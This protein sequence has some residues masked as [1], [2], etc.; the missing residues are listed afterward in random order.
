VDVDI[1]DPHNLCDSRLATSK[2]FVLFSYYVLIF[3]LFVFGLFCNFFTF[4]FIKLNQI[5]IHIKK[6]FNA[7]RTKPIFLKPSQLKRRKLDYIIRYTTLLSSIISWYCNWKGLKSL[8]GHCFPSCFEFWLWV[9]MHPMFQ[10]V[11][12][13]INQI[14]GFHFF[15]NIFLKLLGL[16]TLKIAITAK[17][18]FRLLNVAWKTLVLVRNV[19]IKKK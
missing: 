6:L 18:R 4:F 5:L 12:F 17:V 16:Y 10:I 2:Q 13:H 9:E 7:I 15:F 11:L 3:F 19:F 14:N 8:R 1:L